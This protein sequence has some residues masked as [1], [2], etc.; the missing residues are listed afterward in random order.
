MLYFLYGGK[1]M[2]T[3]KMLSFIIENN[4]GSTNNVPLTDGIIINQE[5]HDQTWLLEILVDEKYREI[6]EKLKV[7]EEKFDVQVIISFPENEP[8]PF[9]VKVKDI[10]Q[11][12]NQISILMIGK[13]QLLRQKYAEKLLESLLEENL[14][15]DLLLKR[16]KQGMKE[17]PRLKL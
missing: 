1:I 11:L 5:N 3:F 8:A 10:L 13:I 2:K 17:R 12:D 14:S 4:D 15:K 16:F 7:S 6:F 9:T